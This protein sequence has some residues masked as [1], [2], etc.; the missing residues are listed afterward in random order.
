MSLLHAMHP[1]GINHCSCRIV[2]LHVY[3]LQAVQPV[4]SNIAL[5]D[6]E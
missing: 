2:P 4:C 1:Y 6:Q 5:L 3:Y